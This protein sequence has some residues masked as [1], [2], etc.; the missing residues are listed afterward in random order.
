MVSWP[1]PYHPFTTFLEIIKLPSDD[2]TTPL[3]SD[4]A[5]CSF[6]S[7][8]RKKGKQL[9]GLIPLMIGELDAKGSNREF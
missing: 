7:F 3:S 2:P 4:L 1:L 5:F 9:C 8:Y 6:R